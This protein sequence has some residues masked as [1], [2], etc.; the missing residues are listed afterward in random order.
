MNCTLTPEQQKVFYKK[1]FK[2][3][4][5]SAESNT[6]FDLKGYVTSI[7]N[8]VSGAKND[9]ALGLTYAQLVP[10]NIAL[11]L[12]DRA[13]RDHIRKTTSTDDVYDLQNSFADD[14]TNVEKYVAPGVPT[15]AEL[16]E[17]KKQ[18]KQSQADKIRTELDSQYTFEALIFSS[19]TTTGQEEEVDSKGKFTGNV[20]QTPR[21]VA[22]YGLQRNILQQLSDNGLDNA[23]SI[24]ILDGKGLFLTPIRE[25]VLGGKS[26][27]I[28]LAFSTK[29]NGETKI[30]YT[31][32]AGNPVAY[33]DSETVPD[34]A[35][36]PYTELRAP[37][38]TDGKYSNPTVKSP[39]DIIEITFPD[40][41]NKAE[42]I[43]QEEIKQQG[44]FKFIKDLIEFS[45]KNPASR[46][47]LSINGGSMGYSN[48]AVQSK[49][50]FGTISNLPEEF[51]LE[52]VKDSK[53]KNNGFSYSRLNKYY[54]P[55]QVIGNPL[56][57]KQ[58]ETLAK[59]AMDESQ[60]A[61][62][63]F[64][65]ISNIINPTNNTLAVDVAGDKLI[66]LS[67]GKQ[68]Y[69]T[70]GVGNLSEEDLT[71][72]FKQ[73]YININ[74]SLIG[75]SIEIPYYTENKLNFSTKDYR[76]FVKENAY[77]FGV[78]RNDGS[79]QQF[80]SYLT[81]ETT[82][83]T[84]NDISEP[85]SKEESDEIIKKA[86][87]N[88]AKNRVSLASVKGEINE[89]FIKNVNDSLQRAGKPTV[90]MSNREI[91]K[92]KNWYNNLKVKKDGQMVNLSSV[93]PFNEAFALANSDVLGTFTTNGIT[94]YT[95]ADNKDFSTL[96]HEAWHGFSQLLLT[97]DQKQKLYDETRKLVPEL[98]NATDL[99]VEEF[100]AEDFRDYVMKDG[101]K[102][103]KGA[104][105]KSLFRRILD[106]LKALFQGYTYNEVASNP[107]GVELIK[108]MYDNLSNGQLFEYEYSLQNVQFGNL[109]RGIEAIDPDY[110]ET[111]SLADSITVSDSI[112]SIFSELINNYG[113]TYPALFSNYPLRIELYKQAYNNFVQRLQEL[114]Q[115][116]EGK[117]PS[118][119]TAQLHAIKVLEYAIDNFGDI[120]SNTGVIA[121]HRERSKYLTFESKFI[122]DS[123]D[124]TSDDLSQLELFE[125]TGNKYSIK[126]LA[127]NQTL[128]MIKS[129]K[130]TDKNGNLI[131]NPLG[132]PKLV[133]FN[134]AFNKI[135]K[136]LTGVENFDEIVSGLSEL[137]LSYKP[138][139]ELLSKLGNP[140]DS[141]SKI[142]SYNMWRG[143]LKSFDRTMIPIIEMVIE[144][145]ANNV[146]TSIRRATGDREKIKREFLSQFTSSRDKYV[147][148]TMSGN[149]LNI[150][151]VLKDF[152]TVDRRNVFE[153]LQAV[154]FY[155]DDNIQIREALRNSVGS[156][157][158]SE[159]I[160]YN[161]LRNILVDYQKNNKEITDP[162]K[163]FRSAGQSTNTNKILDIQ[164]T[165]GDAQ[166]NN[167]VTNVDGN[168][169]FEA[170]DRFS[171][172]N[173]VDDLNALENLDQILTDSRFEHLKPFHPSRNP[174]SKYSLMMRSLFDAQ[175][176]K[177]PDVQIVL[178]NLNGARL[179]ENDETTQG[180]KTNKLTG[181]DKF[182]M[183]VHTFLLNGSPELPRHASKSSAYSIYV[184]KVITDKTSDR[185]YV[186]VSK[187]GESLTGGVEEAM[188]ILLDQL[189]AELGRI[190]F[191]KNT[192]S[193]QTVDTMR[194][195][196]EKIAAFDDV[197]TDTN[198]KKLY[199]IVDK[200]DSVD[201]IRE[202]LNDEKLAE[203]LLSDF[204]RY[205]GRQYN[206]SVKYLTQASFLSPQLKDSIINSVR[207]LSND[208]KVSEI[209]LRTYV[210]NNFIHNF[211]LQL[212]YGDL[213]QFDESKE[214]YHKRIASIASTGTFA[215]IDYYSASLINSLSEN[216]YTA[217]QGYE[218]RGF[219]GKFRS[220]VFDDA[221]PN[222]AYYEYYKSAIEKQLKDRG[223]A[224]AAEK[225]AEIASPYLKIKEGDAQ[226]W[227]NFDSYR[228]FLILIGRWSPEQT[229]LYNKIIN[230]EE[231]NPLEVTETFPVLKSSYYGPIETEAL[232]ITALHK[233]SLAPLI[234]TL[235]KGTHME[236]LLTRMMND[237]ID[238]A[239]YKSGSKIS[240][241]TLEDGSIPGLYSD[242]ATRK[243]YDGPVPVTTVYLKYFKN[244]L[245]IAPKL[246][247]Q[248]T[249]AS[250]LRKLIETNLY[251]N[252]KPVKPEYAGLVSNYEKALNDYVDYF[253]RKIFK[254]NGI[255]LTKDGSYKQSDSSKIIDAIR[256]E[257]IRMEVPEHQMDILNT[258]ADGSLQYNLD[259]SVNSATIE[260]ML[261]AIVERKIVKPKVNG[262][263]LVQVS[264]SGFESTKFTKP[265]TEVLEKYGTNG[266]TAYRLADGKIQPMQVKIALQGQFKKF[267]GLLH[268]D[269]ETIETLERLNQ[270]I[271]N[272]TWNKDNAKN[273]QM[274]G[275]RI[276]V[277]GLN[278]MEYMTVAEFLPAEAGS[279]IIVAPEL[280]AKS[281]SDFDIDKLN[282]L[283][284]HIITQSD[285]MGDTE[286]MNLENNILNSMKEILSIEENFVDL[287]RPNDVAIAKEVSNK[288]ADFNSDYNPVKET[289]GNKDSFY[290]GMS[291]TRAFEFD[292]N[293]YK[294]VSNNI[295]K[296]TL[297]IGA[298]SN[299]YNIV[300]NRTGAYL[301]KTYQVRDSKGK[302][303]E[304]TTKI[305][306]PH[307]E[308]KG[309]VSLSNIYDKA[310]E[311]NIQDIISQLINGWVDIEKDTWIFNLN[312][313][314]EL[315]PTFLFLIQ[316]GVPFEH[317]AYFISQPLIKEYLQNL[318]YENSLFNNILNDKKYNVGLAKYQ[319]RNNVIL[320]N[321]FKLGKEKNPGSKFA[322]YRLLDNLMRTDKITSADFT[323][324]KIAEI[325]NTNDKSSAV[326]HAAFLHFLELQ[327]M[328]SVMRN[329]SSGTNVDTTKGGDLFNAAKRVQNLV[330]LEEN[331]LL[332]TSVTKKIQSESPISPFFIQGYIIN[333][334]KDLFPV[335]A[336]S[337]LN[338]YLAN[339]V[340]NNIFEIGVQ[341]IESF[342]KNFRND[343]M[344]YIFQNT[345]TAV[346]IDNIKSYKGF[347]SS[348]KQ[349]L[350]VEQV[351]NLRR[352]VI[353]KDGTLYID[354]KQ[355]RKQYMS[356]AWSSDLYDSFGLYRLPADK[357][358]EPV[359]YFPSIRQYSSFVVE[360]EY[361][362]A[363][364]P[365][366]ADESAQEFE[367]RIANDALSNTFNLKQIFFTNN[368]FADQL[369]A[370]KSDYP[371]LMDEYQLLDNLVYDAS[372][373]KGNYSR[374]IRL[375]GNTKDKEFVAAMNQD[376]ERLADPA[377]MKLE[378]KTENYKLSQFFQKLNVFAFLQSGLNPGLLSFTAIV[379]DAPYKALM[380]GPV[381]NYVKEMNDNILDKFATK[382]I[383]N[384]A[385]KT[386]YRFKNYI[387]ASTLT[388][389]NKN[390]DVLSSSKVEDADYYTYNY[391]KAKIE[392]LTE[393]DEDYMLVYPSSLNNT[394]TN[395]MDN[396]TYLGNEKFADKASA[397][398]VYSTSKTTKDT[399]PILKADESEAI[400]QIEQAINSLIIAKEQGRT[401][402]F[403][404]NGYGKLSTD[405]QVSQESLVYLSQRLF[406]EFGYV[407]PVLENNPE[408]MNYVY[409]S[410]P[411]NI[412]ES[413]DNLENPECGLTGIM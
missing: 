319:A 207:G 226:G 252:G 113:I 299:T 358:G 141:T 16:K 384:R 239:L 147:T 118:T 55:V 92:A 79:L 305:L 260:R 281:G 333:L 290:K 130:A 313:N 125:R 306:L 117:D 89:D 19:M 205:F 399:T 274:V 330:E 98:K 385:K 35:V 107:T 355:I 235:V 223:I 48:E 265:S 180:V 153:F 287:I 71:A 316:A 386:G 190:W 295:G 396:V 115:E 161:Y 318:N 351:E 129:L 191:V 12:K 248:V 394:G 40:A 46:L 69:V 183:D 359:S 116:V 216:S 80:N 104:E 85:M 150:G 363:T 144:K 404:A 293:I 231:V 269:G 356:K 51:T 262:E 307:N 371:E 132:Y 97:V 62:R 18:S 29:V 280:V 184:S 219:D 43:K 200:A 181:V 95:Q 218:V 84:L 332:P 294:H 271:K 148:T 133:E 401:L 345:A 297:G 321:G 314:Y 168:L 398:P 338:N 37:R 165:Y 238:Y 270:A 370:I 361:L 172:S 395:N 402:V 379:S 244:Q 138:A 322:S 320:N 204:T 276:P 136:Q 381:N 139:A 380:E 369:V 197:V 357:P 202:A 68:V 273:L 195:K 201:A 149:K 403:D 170:S 154:G 300:L 272:P 70:D 140:A 60:T 110:T 341:N 73:A 102:I 406:D 111:I 61:Q 364:S 377:V 163:E 36:I 1:V 34:D 245:D 409:A 99:Q 335:R 25:S 352:G 282:V 408:F 311:N 47:T 96:Y 86:K 22:T 240:N 220:V 267:L 308:S 59:F 193:L 310:G 378:D 350:P 192:P 53:A 343:F 331:T 142:S 171:L 374:N 237:K 210:L 28:V 6:P 388:S 411:L 329:I 392:K 20:D 91:K 339:Y 15:E 344:S 176:N 123:E 284:P 291:P 58:A 373:V 289:L 400:A 76:Q 2:D 105:R 114:D 387:Q 327:E 137:S 108:Q 367:K 258:N 263:A 208:S 27:L 42:L 259:L 87:S 368:S 185:L 277:Q 242:L 222:S 302:I 169:E 155:M 405:P 304:R 283:M 3:L 360:R 217:K 93:L 285:L 9:S 186:P 232:N 151:A 268:P 13:I 214:E 221:A 94:I 188:P 49:V 135:S 38:F 177:R 317:A 4:L 254:E 164:L 50:P 156:R 264:S 286:V 249:L 347:E 81:F 346:D 412:V 337:K 376:L 255:E 109:N 224:N 334:F 375:Q 24:D 315:A 288:L 206:K 64:N 157:V 230:G 106:L 143:F 173:M 209:A 152:P 382:F 228:N 145:D 212:F 234:P 266:L 349:E 362:R 187:V 179:V 10:E 21:K 126:D 407:N 393:L 45:Q 121:Y 178:N 251:E 366:T 75:L 348:T 390:I 325:V 391:S 354:P 213:S 131:P 397:L 296:V 124:T 166:Y 66:V 233:F 253:K 189:S 8:L 292:Y 243:L 101:S 128:Y 122:Q 309:F 175:G 174:Y 17:L 83:L 275:V 323:F 340:S 247:N 326:A 278:S 33:L 383:E 32:K 389:A 77:V 103:V 182:L 372:T 158:S 194:K 279:M 229:R 257:F 162:I 227:I 312:A 26:G 241:T 11:A 72:A 211:D 14:I 256:K 120:T 41:P 100:L 78:L 198:K 199:A 246:K 57:D 88:V 56:N 31:D 146:S 39:S 342:V 250:Q 215:N 127:T 196:G 119:V 7:Y 44:Q 203:E 353:F 328:A 236:N 160:G 225:A 112:D 5:T 134:E 410:Q 301:N 65:V 74:S 336:N 365:R 261:V 413:E 90:K 54:K 324:D 52:T 63:R 30:L 303:Q 159:A 167:G 298:V 67:N 82:P 23:D